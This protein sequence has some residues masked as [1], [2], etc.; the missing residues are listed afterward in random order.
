V[1]LQDGGV[2]DELIIGLHEAWREREGG[3]RERKEEA[4]GE[5]KHENNRQQR[6][7]RAS[8]DEVVAFDGGELNGE[9]VVFG[10]SL[11]VF[12]VLAEERQ[13]RGTK[14]RKK[15]RKRIKRYKE[16]TKGKQERLT[17]TT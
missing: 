17:R 9:L 11:D 2:L 12:G 16:A 5:R 15:E 13:K 10:G 14:E 7:R 1:L 8:V 6:T 4:S 3:W